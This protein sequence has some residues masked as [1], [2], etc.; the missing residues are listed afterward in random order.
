MLKQAIM[1]RVVIIVHVFLYVSLAGHAYPSQQLPFIPRPISGQFI[2][3]EASTPFSGSAHVVS[4]S[5]GW[6][7]PLLGTSKGHTASHHAF[8]APRAG[9]TGLVPA[10]LVYFPSESFFSYARLAPLESG[11]K[12]GL[13]MVGGRPDY[14]ISFAD[15]FIDSRV[16][17]PSNAEI[18][19][20][21][22]RK[23]WSRIFGQRLQVLINGAVV[24]S[25][26]PFPIPVV[27]LARI[28]ASDPSLVNIHLKQGEPYSKWVLQ[29]SDSLNWENATVLEQSSALLNV[30]GEVTFPR[31]RLNGNRNFFRVVLQN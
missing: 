12:I 3:P 21:A 14:Q 27:S 17:S 20:P 11:F 19:V 25:E 5:L 16:S 6:N 1:L 22:S 30:F 28:D 15:Q 18:R 9:W 29:W 2:A 7:E 8:S 4:G 23:D 31:I 13:L 26:V 10:R 24:I